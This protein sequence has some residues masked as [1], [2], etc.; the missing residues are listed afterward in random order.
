MFK[1]SFKRSHY[2]IVLAHILGLG[3]ITL[4]LSAHGVSTGYQYDVPNGTVTVTDANQTQILYR[5]DPLNRL[6]QVGLANN[7]AGDQYN[8]TYNAVGKITRAT[9]PGGE[10]A[11]S[12]DRNANNDPSDDLD[13]LASI[14]EFNQKDLIRFYYDHKDRI[15]WIIYPTIAAQTGNEVCYEYD[16]DGR[17]TRVGRTPMG[18]A[19]VSF[20]RD[21][22]EKTDYSYDTRGRL[23]RILHPNQFTTGYV[24]S[25][26]TGQLLEVHHQ[27]NAGIEVFANFFSYV[28]NSER[29]ARIR[30]QSGPAGSGYSFDHQYTYDASGRIKTIVQNQRAISYEYDAFGNRTLMRITDTVAIPAVLP[31]QLPA[32]FYSYLYYP[33]SNRLKEI[34]RNDVFHESFSYDGVGRMTGRSHVTQGTASY[35][36]D[37]RGYLLT[38]NAPGQT[39]YYT[40]DAFG[41]RKSKTVNGVTRYYL[42]APMFGMDQVLAELTPQLT[43]HTIYVYAGNQVIKEEPSGLDRNQ[44]VMYLPGESV[45]SI[46][47][48]VNLRSGA[49]MDEYF[50]DAF[51]TQSIVK[52]QSASLGQMGY[53]GQGY[54]PE[55]RL[56]YLRARYYDPVLG[57]FISTDPF[58]GYLNQPESQNKYVYGNNNP[59]SFIDPLGKAVYVGQHGAVANW[60]VNPAQHTT[61]LLVPNDPQQFQGVPEF[62][63]SNGAYATIGGQAFKPGTVSVTN[64]LGNMY[65]VYNY[66]GDAP[67][68][69]DSLALIP[70]PPNMSDTQH[71]LKYVDTSMTFK[72]VPYS[73][74]PSSMSNSANSN[75]Y[76]GNLL[77][78]VEGGSPTAIPFLPSFA[79][80]LYK[81][82]P[83][84]TPVNNNS[85]QCYP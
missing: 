85:Q 30:R 48:A 3:F 1:Y 67:A 78:T 32:G 13:T 83:L 9:Y 42:T 4:G 41:T 19:A 66:S 57:R 14:S 68:N 37:F 7:P 31:N 74:L 38:V 24:Y 77:K 49:V 54:D 43:P 10:T 51:G 47:Q 79:P 63:Q 73:M 17:I 62:A 26:T 50:Y 60:S 39:I 25:A 56:V 58:S 15:T 71:I 33:N 82:M 22:P 20:C 40:Y 2:R 29:Y 6:S 35:A 36:Y 72:E 55:T 44:D 76:V 69:L 16:P 11:Y 61:I 53:T 80:G 65:S 64:P 46:A 18:Q 34:R 21:A 8:Y 12:Y 27:N 23:S 45:G 70:T 81:N 59:V 75:T 5:Y 52:K 28:P 84:F